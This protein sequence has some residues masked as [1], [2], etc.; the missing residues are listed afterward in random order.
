MSMEMHV[1]G[2]DLFVVRVHGILRRVELEECQRAAV[3]L[4]Q[5]AG[6]ANGLVLLEGFLGWERTDQWGDVSFF[7]EQGSDIEKI[8]IVGPERWRDEAL[9]FAGAGLR[10]TPVR[11]FDQSEGARAWLADK[12]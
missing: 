7:T 5:Q 8:A 1:E 3:Q 6:K 12:P 4:T 11:Y 2:P 10:Q 9:M